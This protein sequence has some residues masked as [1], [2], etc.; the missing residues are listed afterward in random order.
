M[1][2]LKNLARKGL[3]EKYVSVLVQVIMTQ[4]QY[5]IWPNEL[6]V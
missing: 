4:T 6:R 1:F 2:P 3:I 5:T